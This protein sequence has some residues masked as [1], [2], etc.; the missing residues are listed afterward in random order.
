VVSA[1]RTAIGEPWREG[2]TKN[3]AVCSGCLEE[4]RKKKAVRRGRITLD[5]AGEIGA[6]TVG[7]MRN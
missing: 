1:R 5:S 6:P 4:R 3:K 2:E 7:C